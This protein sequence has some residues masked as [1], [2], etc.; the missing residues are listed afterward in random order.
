MYTEE[1]MKPSQCLSN[2]RGNV[3][4]L[5]GLLILPIVFVLGLAMDLDR[6]FQAKS[7]IQAAADSAVIGGGALPQNS[8]TD[9]RIAVAKALFTKN[10]AASGI[11]GL[12]PSLTVSDGTVN[13]HVGWNMPTT[14]MSIAGVNSVPVGVVSAGLVQYPPQGGGGPICLLALDPN[15]TLGIHVQ[16]N[17]KINYPKCWGYSDSTQSTSVNGVGAAAVVGAGTCAVG[18]VSQNG[19][20]TPT[21][22]SGCGTMTDP[23][24]SVSAYATTGSYKPTFTPPTM[25]TS[26]VA[27]GLTLKK[28]TYNLSPGRYCGG[29]SIM[30]GA[31]VNLAAGVYI[32]DGGTL[33]VQSG[34]NLNGTDVLFYLSNS[35]LD[36]PDRPRGIV[37]LCQLP[38]DRGHGSGLEWSLE[39]PGRRYV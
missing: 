24:S 22:V 14:F 16:G 27:T 28:G 38:R 35:S 26:C 23:F 17:N 10:A 8:T 3:S 18:G 19:Q 12:N 9:Q 7:I 34:G 4:I 6:A 5:F 32:I 20:Y 31:T 2:E 11:T 39:H 25:P 15:S 1:N 33:N 29:L 37:E 21:P 13:L 36:Q 30:A